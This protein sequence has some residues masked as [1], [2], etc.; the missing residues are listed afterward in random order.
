MLRHFCSTLRAALFPLGFPLLL[1]L[2]SPLLGKQPVADGKPL[3]LVARILLVQVPA[4]CLRPVLLVLLPPRIPGP[5]PEDEFVVE[6]I[7]DIGKLDESHPTERKSRA[8]GDR[9]ARG[10]LTAPDGSALAMV[11]I[12][13]STGNSLERLALE[14]HILATIETSKLNGYLTALAGQIPVDVAELRSM[15]RD[16]MVFIPATVTIGLT[17]IWWL[18]RRWLA[19]MLAGIAI[20]VV[21]NSTVAI[22]VI[23]N[24]PFTLISSIIP[25][26]LSALTVAALVHLFDAR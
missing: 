23:L 16:N 18:F 25:P 11:V 15:L 10:A 7:I 13:Q 19:V 12:P 22:Y 9:F 8:V 4:V 6:R 3:G 14:Q 2:A 24:Q 17:L 26:L 21:V 5:R 1:L 20:G